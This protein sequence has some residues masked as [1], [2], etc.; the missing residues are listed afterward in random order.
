DSA[1]LDEGCA[2]LRGER[3]ARIAYRRVP[4]SPS[5]MVEVH[6]SDVDLGDLW[7][8][9]H[10]GG[11]LGPG[12]RH[13]HSTNRVCICLSVAGPPV[14]RP[15]GMTTILVANLD[16]HYRPRLVCLHPDGKGQRCRTS[17]RESP[18]ALA[19]RGGESFVCDRTGQ[20][21]RL[22][23]CAICRA[24]SGRHCRP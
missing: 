21:F 11:P 1:T 14:A 23:C 17:H 8:E 18:E 5:R 4:L 12:G 19:S 22:V 6:A 20:T 2:N 13:L 24:S 15:A 16:I 9:S 10:S 7:V 3:Q